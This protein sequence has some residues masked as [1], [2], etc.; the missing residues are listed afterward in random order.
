MNIAYLISTVSALIYGSNHLTKIVHA[1]VL[2][3]SNDRYGYKIKLSLL[4][5][6]I[7]DGRLS[8]ARRFNGTVTLNGISK[9][10]RS[11]SF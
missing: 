8:K 5:G 1:N 11:K 10:Y 4:D 6:T 3:R 9:K 7:I 2:E